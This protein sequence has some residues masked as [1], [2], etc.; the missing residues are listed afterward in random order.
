MISFKKKEE[1]SDISKLTFK[2]EL[3]L[4]YSIHNKEPRGSRVTWL[5]LYSIVFGKLDK[6]Q[7]DDG[8][9]LISSAGARNAFVEGRR[10]IELDNRSF[11]ALVKRLRWSFTKKR[12]QDNLKDALI[13]YHKLDQTATSD[14]ELEQ[15]KQ[16]L[17]LIFSNTERLT[18]RTRL[19]IS[20][21]R[22]SSTDK[23][24]ALNLFKA[25][26]QQHEVFVD[27]TASSDIKW[28]ERNRTE[29]VKADFFL[30]IL[31]AQAIQDE[32]VSEE[33]STAYQQAEQQAGCP[34]I[35]PIRLAFQEP[36]PYPLSKWLTSVEDLFC[37]SPTNTSHMIKELQRIIS[38]IE[39][40]AESNK[41]ASKPSLPTV[42]SSASPRLDVRQVVPLDPLVMETGTMNPQSPFYVVRNSDTLALKAISSQQIGVIS[43][44]GPRQ[45][46]KS[47]LLH[48]I[49]QT[50]QQL[51]KQDVLL[52]FQ[53]LD[54]ATLGDAT[55]FFR[56]F[57]AWISFKL[58]IENRV[59]AYW[60]LPLSNPHLCTTY[61]EEYVLPTVNRPLVLA[62]DK[63]DRVFDTSFRN[64]FFSM[65]RNWY[66]SRSL[67][68]LWKRIDMVFVTSTEPYLF[69][70]NMYQS[71]FNVGEIIELEDF[72]PEQVTDL[73]QRHGR[74]L[75][76]EEEQLLVNLVGGH[77]YLVRR[78]LY[79][80]ATKRITASALFDNATSDQGPFGDHL[81]RHLFQ[82]HSHPELLE[83]LA[84]II[85]DKDNTYPDE[86]IFSRLRG[87]GLVYK[88]GRT[89]VPR[90]RLYADY[91]RERL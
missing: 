29:I 50:A 30:V 68:P 79:M 55:T 24:L 61:M 42:T 51:E 2:E 89:V 7:F 48:H 69:I 67:E 60:K 87:A 71:P 37:D 44:K 15:L 26:S 5:Q 65:L 63:I 22:N 62:I 12:A 19:F 25:L 90:Y 43:I 21:S 3:T 4:R 20:Y 31:S 38:G 45:M 82:L 72:T 35:L 57:C 86:R 73:N 39:I 36:F 46:G 64:D 70:E 13:W 76:P 53:L 17:L 32:L 8:E 56:C 75:Q 80:I 34:T 85:K 1:D 54:S 88:R 52:D 9:D 77:P 14:K 47:S 49:I 16:D 91:F 10:Q 41:P 84:K 58:K 23:E 27:R 18:G 28:V 40:E 66:N 74:P 6:Y 11:V 33:I 59:D 78:T 81:H 83:A